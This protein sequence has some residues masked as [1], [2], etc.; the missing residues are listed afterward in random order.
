MWV[1][2]PAPTFRPATQPVTST[3]SSCWSVCHQHYLRS[4][5]ISPPIRDPAIR[6]PLSA[7]HHPSVIKATWPH[8]DG[9]SSALDLRKLRF[10]GPTLN[11]ALMIYS[12]VLARHLRS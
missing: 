5:T 12:R 9:A 11:P 1:V 10:T 3:L 2:S 7:D 4:V 8:H 6:R